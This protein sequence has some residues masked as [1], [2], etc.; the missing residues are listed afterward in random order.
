LSFNWSNYPLEGQ[1]K[2][3]LEKAVK[4]KVFPGCV[5]AYGRPARGEKNYIWTGQRGIT[6]NQIPVHMELVYDLASITKIIS[7]TFLLMISV[8][9]G[10]IGLETNL[11]RLGWPLQDGWKELRVIDLLTHSSGLPPWRPYY[12][13]K[14]LADRHKLIETILNEPKISLIGEQSLYSD[15]NFIL[16]GFVL[17][18][19]WKKDLASLWA[20]KIARPLKLSATG[21]RPNPL[22]LPVAPTEDGPR[23]GGPLDWPGVKVL[24]PVPLGRVHD[25]NAAFLGGV[26]GHAGLFGTVPEIWK[27]ISDWAQSLALGQRASFGVEKLEDKSEINSEKKAQSNSEK[28]SENSLPKDVTGSAMGTGGL[29]VREILLDFLKARPA[30]RGPVRAAGFDIGQGSIAG[31][32]GHLGYTGG[33][34]WWDPPQD[35]AFVLLTN[36]VQPTARCSQMEGFRNGLAELL[37]N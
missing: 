8:Q 34:V 35:R 9:E 28:N 10:L 2:A 11:T 36:R 17:E 24:G 22:K 15:L 4:D 27:V 30:K 21:F 18:E 19:I 14:E 1:V 12:L 29:V 33:S 25:D 5:L 6:R 26:A 13:N 37:W 16:L 7:T 3:Y 31:A 20:E 32:R 23:M